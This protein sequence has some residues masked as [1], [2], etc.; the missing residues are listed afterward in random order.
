MYKRQEADRAL[1]DALKQCR[2]QLA[3]EAGVP[4]F[5]VFHDATLME[6]IQYRPKD[7]TELLTISGI[8]EVKSE[9]FGEEFL[10]VLAQY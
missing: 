4:P 8:G 6:L 2:K 3:D 5:H 9:R 1:W 10:K 7:N